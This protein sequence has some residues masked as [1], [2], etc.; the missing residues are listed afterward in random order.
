[1]T[2]MSNVDRTRRLVVA[3]FS[4]HH[5]TSR[6]PASIFSGRDTNKGAGLSATEEPAGFSPTRQHAVETRRSGGSKEPISQLHNYKRISESIGKLAP[7]QRAWVVFRYGPAVESAVVDALLV[8]FYRLYQESIGGALNEATWLFARE[9]ITVHLESM[10]L[11]QS[12]GLCTPIYDRPLSAAVIPD[13]SWR[14]TYRKH[15]LATWFMMSEFDDAT[16]EKISGASSEHA[17]DKKSAS[18]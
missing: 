18:G 9:C 17:G 13:K 15:W 5:Y 12:Y 7:I 11:K 2:A 14:R 16:L 10:L 8:Y 3:S 4:R 1:M 6:S